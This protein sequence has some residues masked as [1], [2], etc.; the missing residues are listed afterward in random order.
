MVKP[1]VVSGWTMV[2]K[3][4]VAKLLKTGDAEWII[5]SLTFTLLGGGAGNYLNRLCQ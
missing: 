1:A 5:V 4:A 3:A 2:F